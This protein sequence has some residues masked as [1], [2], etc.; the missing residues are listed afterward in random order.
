MAPFSDEYLYIE[1][2]N[3]VR[4]FWYHGSLPPGRTTKSPV[5]FITISNRIL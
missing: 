3:K 5:I 2:A 1:I 4:M